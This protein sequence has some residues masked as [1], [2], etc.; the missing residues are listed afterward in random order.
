MSARLVSLDGLADIPLGHVL[1]VVGRHP[2]CDVRLDSVRVSRRHCCLAIDRDGVV[3]RDLGSTNGTRINGRRVEAGLL[4]P[5]DELSIATTRF[6]LEVREARPGPTAE[7]RAALPTP[8]PQ[9][10]APTRS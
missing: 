7:P 3:V 8:P 6:R 2:H 1:T 5:G 10:A 9:D 4:R